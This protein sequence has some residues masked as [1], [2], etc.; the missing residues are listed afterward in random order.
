[1]GRKDLQK[2]LDNIEELPSLPIIVNKVLEVI[3]DS[4]SVAGDLAD[5]ISNDQAFT[6][7]VLR[8]VNSSFYGFSTRISTISRAVVILGYNTIKNLILGLSVIG[9]MEGGEE[10][11]HFNRIEFW[12]HCIG[13]AACSRLIAIR[14]GYSQPEEIFVAGLLH[15]I[16]KIIFNEHCKDDFNRVLELVKNENLTMTEAENRVL[17]V[18]HA[19]MG[20]WLTKKWKFPPV[21]Y[22]TI[23]YHH[24]PP[25][26]SKTVD[27]TVIICSSIVNISDMLCKTG[28]I[29]SD[30]DDNIPYVDGQVWRIINLEENAKEDILYDLDDELERARIFFGIGGD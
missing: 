20:E 12:E 2:I 17:G 27:D 4:R 5:V 10:D 15:D 25:V 3:E 19:I 29:G 26:S 28:G 9:L 6:S 16:G 14:V 11:S 23:R 30:G 1:M 13:C 8:L 18:T 21:L 22:N 7:K 24:S